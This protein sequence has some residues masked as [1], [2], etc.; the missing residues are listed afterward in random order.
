MGHCVQ[1]TDIHVYVWCVCTS[2]YVTDQR[3]YTPAQV[4]KMTGTWSIEAKPIGKF[5]IRKC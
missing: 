3:R 4:N 5:R 1:H 2:M